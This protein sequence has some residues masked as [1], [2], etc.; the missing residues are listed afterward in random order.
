[1]DLSTETTANLQ[2]PPGR[3]GIAVI[4]I[5]G[6]ETRRICR[7]LFRPRPTHEQRL[8]RTEPA[9]LQLGDLMDEKEVIDEAIVSLTP[10]GAEINIH[11]G[12]LVARRTLERLTALGVT[13]TAPAPGGAFEKAHPRWRNP[14]VGLEM[15]TVLPEASGSLLIEGIA[16]QWSGGI[17]KLARESLNSGHVLPA[18]LARTFRAAAGGLTIMNRLLHPAEVVLAGPPNAGKSTLTN[19][20]IGRPVSIIHD[21]PGTTRD[22]VREPASVCGVPIYL[23]D[24][25]GLWETEHEID[26]ESVRRAWTRIDHADL[27]LLTCPAGQDLQLPREIHTN[28]IRLA[29]KCDQTQT[30]ATSKHQSEIRNPK[31][32]ILISARTGEGM[33]RLKR[34]ILDAL[35]AADF[36]RKPIRR[37][38]LLAVLDRQMEQLS[39]EA[40]PSA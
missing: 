6:P 23:T 5:A 24:T 20:L 12:P 18:G 8:D 31:S 38:E 33:D 36:I 34:A 25:A 11:G 4:H 22:W 29:T 9:R 19:A 39:R 35:G 26:A 10:R 16:N 30:P 13:I 1:M 17:S 14:A 40:S 3:G 32:E 28:T 2:T 15:L 37:N 7:L 27:V 21:R